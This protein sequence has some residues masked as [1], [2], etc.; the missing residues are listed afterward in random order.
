MTST[1]FNLGDWLIFEPSHQ[2]ADK[3]QALKVLEEAS[4]VVEAAKQTINANTVQ[5]DQAA[6]ARKKLTNEI[7]DLLQTIVNLCDAFDIT[8]PDLVAAQYDCE[9]KN[10]DRGMFE[11]TPRTH[12]HRE[13]PATN[14]GKE[15]E[16]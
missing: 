2:K 11:P 4:E 10:L 12:M 5:T 8:E 15:Q 1:T 3:W 16:A 9:H 13:E 6:Q 7:A 14:T